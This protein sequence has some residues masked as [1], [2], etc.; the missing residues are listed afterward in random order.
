MRVQDLPPYTYRV[1]QDEAS[2]EYIAECQEIRG[3]SGIGD[4]APEAVAELQE[5]LAGW[6]EVL[7]EQ[8]VPFPPPEPL[9]PSDAAFRKIA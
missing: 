5:A 8:G 9:S 2:G 3:L 6:L 1:F 7:E 4:T